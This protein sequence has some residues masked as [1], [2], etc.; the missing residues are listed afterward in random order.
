MKIHRKNHSKVYFYFVIKV[1]ALST[2]GSG[3]R[4][5]G[6]LTF[7]GRVLADL[8]VDTKIGKLLM[9]GHVF[10]LLQECLIIGAAMS[11]KSVFAQPFK[12]RLEAYRYLY[13]FHTNSQKVA[14][15]S[16]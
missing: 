13:L 12:L 2:K 15:Y 3:N 8:P 16:A 11:L 4:H 6:E 1:G 5:D 10:G 9:L 14:V 7:V